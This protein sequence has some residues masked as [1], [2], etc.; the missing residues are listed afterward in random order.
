MVNG[1]FTL[2]GGS[3]F[4]DVIGRMMEVAK[5]LSPF[6]SRLNLVLR[7]AFLSG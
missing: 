2:G 7:H 5:P 3:G 4:S 6:Y 1:G